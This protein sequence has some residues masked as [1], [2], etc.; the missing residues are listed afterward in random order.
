[1]NWFQNITRELIEPFETVLPTIVGGLLGGFL[2]EL[3]I[4]SKIEIK[5]SEKI[6]FLS[7]IDKQISSLPKDAY[8]ERR[9]FN[10]NS[11][12]QF[13]FLHLIIV[14]LFLYVAGLIAIYANY[15][16][17]LIW[18][19]LSTFSFFLGLNIYQIYMQID[20]YKQR[21]YLRIQGNRSK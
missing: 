17:E 4:L 11:S 20:S 2:I 18:D 14:V 10:F 12:I 15:S 8:L 9:K 13:L 6:S 1:L 19:D 3:Y 5:I 7:K 21:E 16:T